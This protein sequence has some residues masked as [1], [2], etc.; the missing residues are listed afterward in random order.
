M[1]NQ[2][3]ELFINKTNQI[4]TWQEIQTTIPELYPRGYISVVVNK[5]RKTYIIENVR[6]EGFIYKGRKELKQ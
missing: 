3:L 5:L 2:L 1:D 4:T 6:G